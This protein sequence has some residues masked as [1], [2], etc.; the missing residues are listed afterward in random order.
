MPRLSTQIGMALWGVASV[1]L[2]QNAAPEATTEPKLVI[3][4]A[5]SLSPGQLPGLAEQ[6]VQGMKGTLAELQGVYE[7]AKDEKDVVKTLCLN[8]KVDQVATAVDTA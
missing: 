6:Y 3:P 8:D 1:A 2:A 7:Q 4:D 5:E